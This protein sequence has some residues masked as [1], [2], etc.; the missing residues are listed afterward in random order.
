MKKTKFK[1]EANSTIIEAKEM[2][3]SAGLV[4]VNDQK[5]GLKRESKGS[6]FVYI[7]LNHKAIKDKKTIKRIQALAIP[8]A[9]TDVWICP[10]PNG[11]LQATGRDAK[12][13]KQYRYHTRWR[14][15]SDE[16]KYHKMI[17]FARALPKIRK[18]IH[19]DLALP[20]IQKEKILATVVYLLEVTLIRV[21]NEAY[22]KENKSF[23]LTTLRNRHV[24]IEGTKIFFKFR[25]KSGQSHVISLKNPRLAKIV[26]KCRDLPGQDLFEY[27]DDTG[28]PVPVN[29]TEVNAYLKNITEDYF[30]AKD[31]RTWAGTVLA[32][33]ALQEFQEFDTDVQAKKNIVRAIEKVA[34]KLGNTPTVCRKCYVHPEVFNGYLDGTLLQ[35]IR[36]R[37]EQELTGSLHDLTPEEAAVLAFL[38]QRL[39]L[40][41]EKR[42]P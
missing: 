36:Q 13:R 5:P 7:G 38:Q 10:L 6:H 21:G 8:P 4:Y 24:E 17:A 37:A 39:E 32:T 18:R 16:T 2:A 3:E 1:E 27:L 25:G 40:E 22:A 33:F 20:G 23:G 12:G 26:K 14:A 11:H 29:S 34:K 30:T 41:I 9:Y 31:F 35:T 42:K 19:Q 15:I 28:N